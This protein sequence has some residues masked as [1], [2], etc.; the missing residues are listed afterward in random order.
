MHK[1]T[2]IHATNVHQGGGRFLL[3]ALLQAI[4]GEVV[5]S[6]DERMPLSSGMT[7]N[8]QV[9][10]VK[11]SVLQ[12]LMAEKW[13]AQVV[14]KDDVVLCFGNLPPLFRLRGYTVV[15]LQNRYL[16]EDVSLN[17]FPFKIR[18]RLVFERFWL[19]K[20][21]MHADEFVVQTP[22]MKKLLES[23][24]QK[25][26]PVSL[27]PFVADPSGYSRD[28]LPSEDKDIVFDFVYVAS[29]ES[30]KNHQRLIQA[31]CLL[32]NE[33][34]YPSLCLTL[35]ETRF[36]GLCGLIKDMQQRYGIRITNVGGLSHHDV[37][38][39]YEKSGAAIYP[40][41]FESFGLPLV[42]ARQANLPVLASELDY[43]RDV[44]DPEQVFNPE[45]P[46]SIARAVKRYME[47][48]ENPLLL[49][50]ASQ[51]L[52]SIFKNKL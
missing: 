6:V 15:F 30:H 31:W 17:G 26:T 33:R 22:T 29:G 37:L 40:S 27:L 1:R 38:S 10:R 50:G 48:E 14:E 44:I 42:E 24:T 13:L 11:P 7:N 49:L 35:D 5:L 52:A 23:K 12:R 21:L 47:I 43:V 8:I 46:V 45:S 34:L 18:F 20:R 3:D 9:K 4:N 2:F 28:A 36:A 41:K 19:A 32:A 25:K 39:L 51:F 16:I